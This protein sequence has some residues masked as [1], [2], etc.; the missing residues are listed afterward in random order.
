MNK[1]I[2]WGC[3]AAWSATSLMQ[4]MA[5]TETPSEKYP[6]IDV[7]ATPLEY[8]QFEKVEITGSSVIARE[9]KETLPIQVISRQDIERSGAS[10]LPQMLQKLPGMFN[11]FELGGMTGTTYGGARNGRYPWQHKWHPRLVKWAP[12]AFLRQPDHLWRARHR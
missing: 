11:F 10:N 1:L 8:R 7:R 4:A 3:A 2:H 5:S 6:P 9:A 12:T